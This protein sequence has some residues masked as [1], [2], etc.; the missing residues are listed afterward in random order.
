VQEGTGP[1]VD[2]EKKKITGIEKRNIQKGKRGRLREAKIFDK[3]VID[4]TRWELLNLWHGMEAVLQWDRAWERTTT[5]IS[6]GGRT[7]DWTITS[8]L[9]WS[10]EL[11]LM[12]RAHTLTADPSYERYLEETESDIVQEGDRILL[13]FR[14]LEDS[15]DRA[16]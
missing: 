15:T 3:Q 1:Q 8:E 6:E 7:L 10:R 4:E 5:W 12:V 13:L 14:K 2:A 9:R 16:G 11:K